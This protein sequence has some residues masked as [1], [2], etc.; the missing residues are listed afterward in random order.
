LCVCQSRAGAPR[1]SNI[2]IR[3]A[4]GGYRWFLTQVEPVR[5]SDGTLLYWIG[6]NLDIEERQQAEQKLEAQETELRQIVNLTPTQVFVFGPDGNPL[7][8]NR[9]ALEYFGVDID[10]LLAPSRIN[11]VHPDDRERYL[12]EKN[13]EFLRG[14][15]HEIEARMLKHDGTYRSF[16]IRRNP[17]KDEQGNVTRW[18]STGID[19]EDR[20]RAEQKLQA[21]EMELRQVLDLTPQLI[22]VFG[23]NREPFYANR[24]A[25]DYL[26]LSLDDW[27]QGSF[28]GVHPDDLERLKG[29]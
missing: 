9:V 11:F 23:P 3:N 12:V 17:F 21:Q 26:G 29:C 4:E 24:T 20:K 16:L 27:R 10:Q 8:A 25:L 22:G 2:R 6:V 18:Y 5:A 13:K 15:P 28:G 14:V 19:I 1:Q 7:Y